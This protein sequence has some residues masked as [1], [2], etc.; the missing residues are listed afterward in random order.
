MLYVTAPQYRAPR[1]FAVLGLVLLQPPALHMRSQMS[2][3]MQLGGGGSHSRCRASCS[4]SPRC[5]HL[6]HHQVT[7]TAR[8]SKRLNSS[9]IWSSGNSPGFELNSEAVA[10]QLQPFAMTVEAYRWLRGYSMDSDVERSQA[11]PDFNAIFGKVINNLVTLL[12]AALTSL[13]LCMALNVSYCASWP[14]SQGVKAKVVKF[15]QIVV[16]CWLD[17]VSCSVLHSCCTLEHL[18][19]RS[20]CAVL[21]CRRVLNPVLWD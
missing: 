9:T 18:L 11:F 20:S 8:S 6:Q 15:L 10:G 3:P 5:I 1:E 14:S 4:M 7:R 13:V 12:S 17:A 16:C 21:C 19:L 2:S